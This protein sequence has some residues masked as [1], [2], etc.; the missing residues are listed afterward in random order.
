MKNIFVIIFLL[1][2]F[3]AYGQSNP[4]PDKKDSLSAVLKNELHIS[5]QIADSVSSILT[6]ASSRMLS[7]INNKSLSKEQKLAQMH[8][9]AAQRDQK[10]N[11]LLT[12]SQIQNLKTIMSA[13]KDRI[14]AKMKAT[15]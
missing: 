5:Q 4:M 9:V 13:N 1:L 7:I 10:I 2:G 8:E 12:A 3:T 14:K 11:G 15:H 6:T